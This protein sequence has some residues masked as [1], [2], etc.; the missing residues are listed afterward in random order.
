MH[1]SNKSI[2]PQEKLKS[3]FGRIEQ[4]SKLM[5]SQF[6]IGN[7]SF[8]LDPLLNFFPIVGQIVSF[9]ISFLL[10][11]VMFRHGVSSKAAVKMGL[12]VLTDLC[13]S[14]IPLIGLGGDFF[15]K[16]NKR[17]VK[18]LKAHYFEGKNQGSAKGILLTIAAIIAVIS[19]LILYSFWLLTVWFFEWL[20]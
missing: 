6:K 7:F 4:A 19:L 9:G 1:I 14:S 18:L 16:A 5:D 2:I 3:D 11:L 10:V 17:N 20:F 12:N 13:I 15:F 8:G